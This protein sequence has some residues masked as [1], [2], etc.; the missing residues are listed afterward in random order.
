MEAILENIHTQDFRE[1]M[2]TSGHTG[3]RLWI[4]PKKVTGILYQL[5][6]Y[7]AYFLISILAIAPFL[8]IDG[9]P[10]FLFNIIERKFIFFAIPFWPQDFHLVAIGL[11]T[12]MVFIVLFTVVFGRVWC[13]WVCPQ[14]IFME[15]VFRRIEN[16]IEGDFT[17]QKK[18]D[19][20][21][22]TSQ[23]IFKKTLK[24]TIFFTISFVIANIF[25]AYFIGK[26]E[27]IKLITESPIA[28]FGKLSALL[29][30]TSIFYFVFARFR[31]L[32]CIIVCPYGRLQGVLLDKKSIVVAYD[33]LRG[34]PRGKISNT[35]G[36]CVDCKLCVHVC[37][38]GI[39]IR[40]GTQ[41]ECVNC[42]A[43]IDVCN[44]VMHKIQKPSNL[45]KYASLE[46]IEQGKKLKFNTRIAAYSTALTLLSSLLVFL[47][48]TRSDIE[49]T[50][51]R[52]P[53]MLFQTL[54]NGNISNL[55][56]FELVNK[57]FNN[58]SVEAISK[59]KG[60]SIKIIGN[61]NH[62]L[63]K[64]QEILKGALFVEIPQNEIKSAK[65]N[66]EIDFVSNGKVIEK[67][68]TNFL[69]PNN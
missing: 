46:G 67:V 34:E 16:W 44:E 41:L 39:D 23:K 3:K 47:L 37:P 62:F 60:V 63:I 57:T 21:P 25:L 32:V 61:D 51:L 6:A 59:T 58:I 36:D 5:R 20:S 43:C 19:E 17:Q 64:K 2:S 55:Y 66:I 30:F 53:G 31:E 1:T 54:P 38:T 9:H 11:L 69:G 26:T 65:T 68:K 18:F 49:A 33:Y 10:I 4:Y 45:I 24:H 50:V 40:N 42:T 22:T 15:M 12:F 52:T 27:L 35:T 56:N 7:F 13:G 28:N 48:I 8:E 29:V 14:T